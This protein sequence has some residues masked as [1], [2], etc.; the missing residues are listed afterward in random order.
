[1]L[2]INVLVACPQANRRWTRI[3]TCLTLL[4]ITATGIPQSS[5]PLCSSNYNMP[6]GPKNVTGQTIINLTILTASGAGWP[7]TDN[8]ADTTVQVALSCAINMWNTALGSNGS[9]IPYSF[10]QVS[11]NNSSTNV[12]AINQGPTPGSPVAITSSPA[13]QMVGSQQYYGPADVMTLNPS[14]TTTDTTLCAT[15]AHE[16]GHVLGLSDAGSGSIMGPVVGPTQNGPWTNATQS[17]QKS[18]VNS[19]QVAATNQ[20]QCKDISKTTNNGNGQC[21]GSAPNDSCFCDATTN[22]YQCGCAGSAPICSDGTISVCDS[23]TWECGSVTT[24]QCDGTPPCAGA[25][26]NGENSW[27]TSQCTSV[28]TSQCDGTPPCS[29]AVCTADSTWDISACNTGCTDVCDTSC[30]DYDYCS[31]YPDDPS[32]GGGGGGCNE[33]GDECDPSSCEYDP[34]DC[35]CGDSTPVRAGVDPNLLIMHPRPDC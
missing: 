3:V 7:G 11:N 25:I 24:S 22:T 13:A 2:S 26:C 15:M 34:V 9:T 32:C 16:L 31:C 5:P 19:V 4:L 12:V 35:E 18:D 10:V 29:G 20:S 27:D 8:G 30:S 33:N 1:M 23:D 14:S 6:T 21:S 28:T 17:I